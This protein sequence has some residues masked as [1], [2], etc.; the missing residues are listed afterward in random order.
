MPPARGGVEVVARDRSPEYTRA[1][2]AAAPDAVQVADRW[3][4]LLNARQATERWLAAIHGRLRQLPAVGAPATAARTGAWERSRADAD[5]SV[6]HWA[7]WHALYL[8]VR[9]RHAAGEPITRIARAMALARG[10]A[11]RFAYAA[12]YPE[13]ARHPLRPSILD[14]YIPYLAERLAAGCENALQLWREIVARGYPGGTSRVHRWLRE[15]RSAPARTP[16]RRAAL[17]VRAAE[18]RGAPAPLPS[19]KQLAWLVGQ[20]PDTLGPADAAPVV[21]ITQD[22]EVARGVALVRRFVALVRERPPD[23]AVAF[24]A[25]LADARASGIRALA[26]FAAGL[27]QDGAA[28]R[29]ALTTSWSNGQTEGH[30][31]KLKL[32]KRQMYGRA[33]FDLLRRRVLLAA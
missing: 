10:T 28:V 4:L 8:E 26:T 15:R 16:P 7:R 18:R 14:P 27:T 24:E 5:V 6:A 2:G 13:R 19:P 23:A 31:A 17:A 30:V 21:R 1:V 33:N 25:W 12:S 9:R 22:A 3:H 29:A 20:P 32:L 11:R